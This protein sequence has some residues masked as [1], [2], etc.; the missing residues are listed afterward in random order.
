MAGGAVGVAAH[1][2]GL[3]A[4]LAGR[5]AQDLSSV[6]ARAPRLLCSEGVCL[7]LQ[8]LRLHAAVAA[9]ADV[10][11]KEVGRRAA[12][13]RAGVGLSHLPITVEIAS[14]VVTVAWTGRGAPPRALAPLLT[15]GVL[16]VPAWSSHWGPDPLGAPS[17]TG[18]GVAW[19]PLHLPGSRPGEGSARG[20]GPGPNAPRC[21]LSP[22]SEPFTR[23]LLLGGIA[24]IARGPPFTLAQRVAEAAAA[25]A[26]GIIVID[27][28]GSR[29]GTGAFPVFNQSCVAGGDAGAGTGFAA[30]DEGRLW[31]GPAAHTP[32]V[33]IPRDIGLALWA[34]AGPPECR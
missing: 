25:G 22:V 7:P 15:D 23:S 21:A 30:A 13:A 18:Q 29:C 12:A 34:A 20:T 6:P 5:G 8:A 33:I 10:E 11:A 31:G 24:I 14:D 19:D 26:R 16:T 17:V 9:E 4:A 3:A 27:D 1:L 28:A 32:A 2:H